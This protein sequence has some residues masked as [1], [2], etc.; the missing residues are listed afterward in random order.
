MSRSKF[1]VATVS[2]VGIS[3]TTLS[4]LSMPT[5]QAVPECTNTNATTTQCQRPGGSVQ[6]NTAPNPATVQNYQWPWWD[7][8]VNI[9]GFGFGGFG[10]GG[11]GRR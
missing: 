7:E 10:F 9:I 8:G 2:I 5:A 11:F 4:A 3:V 6:I 1:H